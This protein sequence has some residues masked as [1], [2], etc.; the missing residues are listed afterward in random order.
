MHNKRIFILI[1]PDCSQ[2]VF[3]IEICLFILANCPV[4]GGTSRFFHSSIELIYES[5]A[6]T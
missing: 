2:F 3:V 5:P 4:F 6:F 1:R